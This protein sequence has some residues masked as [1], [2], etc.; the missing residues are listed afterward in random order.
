MSLIDNIKT[1]TLNM[2]GVF[3][4]DS[5]LPANA[6]EGDHGVVIS[7]KTFWIYGN[8]SWSDSGGTGG[9][10]GSVS[11]SNILGAATSNASLKSALD[12]KTNL[13]SGAVA[14]HLLFTNANGQPQN[15]GY[16][17]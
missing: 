9:G 14:N 16:R 2:R 12:G 10:A 13:V 5:D 1:K 6:K 17:I 3:E 8:G 7:T 4:N 15:S 11:F